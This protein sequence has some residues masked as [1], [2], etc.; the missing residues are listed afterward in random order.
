MKVVGCQPNAPA[1]NLK[2]GQAFA[3]CRTKDPFTKQNTV[4]DGQGISHIKES[5]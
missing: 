2:T 5:V 1:A 3:N 4:S